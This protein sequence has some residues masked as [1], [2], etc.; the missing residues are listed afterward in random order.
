M[1]TP[2][3]WY[4]VTDLKLR[5]RELRLRSSS[6]TRGQLYL[7]FCKHFVLVIKFKGVYRF[8]VSSVSASSVYMTN[9]ILDGTTSFPATPVFSTVRVHFN[10]SAV[11]PSV[12]PSTLAP[13]V[14]SR[15]VRALH[16]SSVV[17]VSSTLTP[18]SS[19]LHHSVPVRVDLVHFNYL[20]ALL[21][22]PII[23]FFFLLLEIRRNWLVRLQ[24]EP[25]ILHMADISDVD[26]S[27]S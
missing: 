3:G 19:V 22:F 15:S 18:C 2:V 20:Y 23:F 17:V 13:S 16:H 12:F 27:V 25:K 1:L 6:R 8:P 4:P 7:F 10:G 9:S 26:I 24:V 11:S 21:V 14:S 5:G